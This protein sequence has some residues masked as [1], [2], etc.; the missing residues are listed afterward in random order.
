M[1]ARERAAAAGRELSEEELAAM[2][3]D[4]EK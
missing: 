1:F 4:D 2:D 3:H